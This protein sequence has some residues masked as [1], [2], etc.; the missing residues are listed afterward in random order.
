[1][2]CCWLYPVGD[3]ARGRG[4]WVKGDTDRHGP[5]EGRATEGRREGIISLSHTHAST[6]TNIAMKLTV[7]LVARTG[8]LNP[9]LHWFAVSYSGSTCGCAD[10]FLNPL[11]DRELDL[12][13][14]HGMGWDGPAQTR[15]ILY[16]LLHAS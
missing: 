4:A 3:E 8:E 13:G 15:R 7:E 6:T 2:L 1:M 14:E 11:K 9:N 5:G 12:R 10:S 16:A